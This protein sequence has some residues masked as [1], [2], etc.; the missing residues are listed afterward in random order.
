MVADIAVQ[1]H[2]WQEIVF[3]DDN[4][5]L[6]FPLGINIIG[7]S[8]DALAHIDDSDIFVAV[9]DNRTREDIILKLEKAG[10][11]IPILIHPNSIMGMEVELESGTVV[12]AGAVI[13]C[14]T[15]IGKGCII[16]TGATV[17]HDNQIGDYV[18]ISPGVHLAGTVNIGKR[19][20]LGIGSIVNNNLSIV[21]GSTIGAG[22]VVIRDITEPSIYVGIPARKILE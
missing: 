8:E 2:Q 13:N 11:N 22:T 19:V 10:A 18:H 3:L 4:E 14:C 20:W 7:K 9:G 21:E 17:D 1:M 15:H 12:M 6:I 5:T 16:N